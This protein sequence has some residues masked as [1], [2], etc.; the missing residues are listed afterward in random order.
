MRQ[1]LFDKAAVR[2]QQ[3][4]QMDLRVVN[5][6]LHTL[7]YQLFG[8]GHQGALTQVVGT[9][10]ERQADKADL[11]LAGRQHLLQGQVE[12]VSI[13]RQDAGQH[14]DVNVVCFCQVGGGA[15]VLGQTRT[16][17]SETGAQVGA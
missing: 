5:R 1:M 11:S 17:E 13:R 10:L 4:R 3:L 15:Q 16:T 9:G 7:A 12:M 8:Q 14:R 6:Q 2:T